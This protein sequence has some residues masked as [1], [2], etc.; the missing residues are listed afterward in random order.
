MLKRVISLTF[1]LIITS[2]PIANAH[3]ALVSSSPK[4]N[5]MLTASPKYISLTFNEEL[6]AI[7]GKDVSNISLINAKGKEIKLPKAQVIHKDIV[8]VVSKLPASKYV[9]KYRVVS[10]DGH[11]VSGSFNFW[12]H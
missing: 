7:A 10:A 4:K 5:A 3:T 1:A 8:V 9:V 6:I 12:V 2:M 11:P